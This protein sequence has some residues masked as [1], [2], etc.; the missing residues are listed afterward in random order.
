MS[1]AITIAEYLVGRCYSLQV[2]IETRGFQYVPTIEQ[3]MME[4]MMFRKGV[5]R[6]NRPLWEAIDRFIHE[7]RSINHYYDPF[8]ISV[9]VGDAADGLA[10][11]IVHNHY[12][13]N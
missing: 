9:L 2:S 13:F 7:L 5:R 11:A 10:E 8:D 6:I 3:I 1:S 12:V 4:Y